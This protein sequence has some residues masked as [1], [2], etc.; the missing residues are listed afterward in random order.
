[1]LWIITIHPSIIHVWRLL[2]ISI[3]SS[4]PWSTQILGKGHQLNYT[5]FFLRSYEYLKIKQLCQGPRG[6]F[7]HKRAEQTLITEIQFYFALRQLKVPPS[8]HNTRFF[9]QLNQNVIVRNIFQA[10]FTTL[11]LIVIYIY[12]YVVCSNLE[13][14]TF[15]SSVYRKRII[16]FTMLFVKWKNFR[17][18][19]NQMMRVFSI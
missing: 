18:K 8:Q 2:F 1:M 16:I 6:L 4:C 10:I 9:F 3:F 5:F 17:L 12:T 14:T 13:S 15:K 7:T 19:T 11:S